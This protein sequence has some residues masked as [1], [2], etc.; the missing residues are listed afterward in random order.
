MA[1]VSILIYMGTYLKARQSGRLL[2]CPCPCR[3]RAEGVPQRRDRS[4]MRSAVRLDSDNLCTNYMCFCYYF[5]F[6]FSP[7]FLLTL[8]SVVS[9]ISLCGDP[10]LCLLRLPYSPLATAPTFALIM[11]YAARKKSLKAF[12]PSSQNI[13]SPFLTVSSAFPPR[14][15][16]CRPQTPSRADRA[17]PGKRHRLS[18]SWPSEL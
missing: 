6:L 12:A 16:P 1:G 18:Q 11:A 14:A 3:V 17:P 15:P 2:S 8:L 4:S 13:I 7:F 10:S 9:Y 5:S